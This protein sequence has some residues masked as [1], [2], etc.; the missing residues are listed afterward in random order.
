M[1]QRLDFDHIA[2]RNTKPFVADPLELAEDLRAALAEATNK[3]ARLVAALRTSKK[4]KK[5]LATVLTGLKQL[6]L[7]DGGAR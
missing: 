2:K 5:A 7:T 3:A 6:N 4:E 1:I